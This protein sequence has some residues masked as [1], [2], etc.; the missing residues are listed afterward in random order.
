[1]DGF[2]NLHMKLE[3]ESVYDSVVDDHLRVFSFTSTA[4]LKS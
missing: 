3:G 2:H 4:S 1:M